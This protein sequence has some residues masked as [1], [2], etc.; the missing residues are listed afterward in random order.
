LGCVILGPT[1]TLPN[2]KESTMS[3]L[4]SILLH[5]DPSPRSRTRLLLARDLAEKQGAHLTALYGSTPSIMDM[6]YSLNEGAAAALPVLEK[7]DTDRRDDAR[8]IFDSVSSTGPYPLHWRELRG[9]HVVTGVARHALCSDLMVLGQH[10]PND[11]AALAIPSDF[12]ASVMIASGKPA[13]IIP[14]ANACKT[15]GQEVL[16]AWVPTREC[17]RALMS[18]IPFLQQAQRIHL[19]VQADSNQ[20]GSGASAVEAF[21][22]LHDINVPV[23]RHTALPTNSVGEALLSL[24]SDTSADLL[25]MGCYSHSRARELVFG[26]ATRTLLKSMTLPVLMAH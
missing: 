15:L 26:G 6:P 21:L 8:A 9:E 16:I 13:L 18:A 19:V 4:R 1:S 12:I 25:V 22:K 17:A 5:L 23:K 3:P 10:D 14:Y 7:L 2:L 11:N 24:A 20:E